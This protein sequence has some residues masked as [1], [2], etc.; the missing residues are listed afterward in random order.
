MRS[1]RSQSKKKNL[2][3]AENVFFVSGLLQNPRHCTKRKPRRHGWQVFECL[4]V[5]TLEHYPA[6]RLC[7]H[8]GRRLSPFRI[9]NP[10]PTHF[11][12]QVRCLHRRYCS[13][14]RKREPVSEG[15]H[16][17]HSSVPPF[18]ITVARLDTRQRPKHAIFARPFL[19][20]SVEN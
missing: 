12:R 10:C 6:R 19:P 16:R 15:C 8:C 2:E 5:A 7:R 9:Q 20:S 14:C 4:R 1:T 3:P 18:L 13:N 11:Q 17:H